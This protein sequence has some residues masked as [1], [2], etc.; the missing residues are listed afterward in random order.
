VEG[1]TFLDVV[2]ADELEVGGLGEDGGLV[3]EGAVA[4]VKGKTHC[5]DAVAESLDEITVG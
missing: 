2:I 3:V 1:W 5:N 4:E